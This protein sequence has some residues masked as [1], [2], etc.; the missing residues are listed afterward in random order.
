MNIEKIYKKLKNLENVVGKDNQD[1]QDIIKELEIEKL[2]NGKVNKSIMSTFNRLIKTN[3]ARPL[4]QQ[5]FKSAN[6]NNYVLTNGYFLIDYGKDTNNIPKELNPYIEIK[7]GTKPEFN[8]EKLKNK[9]TDLK[10]EKIK[11]ADMEKIYK[12][13]KLTKEQIFYVID[14]K[15]FNVEYLLDIAKLSGQKVDEIVIENDL[16]DNTPIN[17]IFENNIRAIL[18]PVKRDLE[19]FEKT[20]TEFNK[21]LESGEY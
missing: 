1:L 5:I 9:N 6:N 13:K 17:I 20:K 15:L 19:Y 3:E 11:I 12:Y 21:I 10:T 8:Y 7:E 4:F 14:N 16:E 18:L 2:T